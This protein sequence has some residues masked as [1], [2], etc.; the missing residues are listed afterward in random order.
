MVE[1]V[2]KC[3]THHTMTLAS[4][5]KAGAIC[6]AS[7]HTVLA[8]LLLLPVAQFAEAGQKVLAGHELTAAAWAAQGESGWLNASSIREM[9]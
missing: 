7:L 1:T 9:C 8:E 3:S 6:T 2:S 5:Q 4:S